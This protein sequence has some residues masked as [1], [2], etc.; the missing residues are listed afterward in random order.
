MHTAKFILQIR[1]KI[2]T[3]MLGAFSILVV[4][5]LFIIIYKEIRIVLTFK[6]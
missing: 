5:N 4:S 6:M 3:E 2:L 1:N